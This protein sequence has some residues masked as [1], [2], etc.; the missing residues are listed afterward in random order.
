MKIEIFGA[1]CPRCE[2]TH[3]AIINAAAELGVAADIQYVTDVATMADRGIMLTPAVVVDGEVVMKG[4]IPTPAE[5]KA[6][7]KKYNK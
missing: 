3:R 6:L 4:R 7:L 1:G 2:Q 5:A